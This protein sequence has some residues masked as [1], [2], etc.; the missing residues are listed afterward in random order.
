MG[1]SRKDANAKTERKFEKKVE[2]YAKV[3]DSV[4]LNATKSI[5][6]VRI[7]SAVLYRSWKKKLRSRQRKLKAYDFTALSEF[8][9]D[10][11]APKPKPVAVKEVKLNSKSRKKILETE[12]KQMNTILNHPAFL[13]DPLGSIHQHLQS[14]QPPVEEKPRKKQNKN[15]NNKSKSKKSKASTSASAGPELMEY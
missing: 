4:S 12:K 8:L 6:K 5:T 13:A 3:K 14:T 10:V 9:P 11:N 2:F 15:G 1:K 7:I